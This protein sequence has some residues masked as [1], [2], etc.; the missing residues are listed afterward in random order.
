[1]A[2]VAGWQDSCGGRAWLAWKEWRLLSQQWDG[3]LLIL[4][5]G[6][7]GANRSEVVGSFGVSDGQGGW[8]RST[9]ARVASL[10][11]TINS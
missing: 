8:V 1:M 5:A 7:P 2:L 3:W 9:S 10:S 6:C 11:S 4:F